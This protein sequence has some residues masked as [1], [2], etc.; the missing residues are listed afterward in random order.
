MKKLKANI[1]KALL[2]A[3]KTYEFYMIVTDDFTVN[4]VVAPEEETEYRL[5]RQLTQTLRYWVMSRKKMLD[6]LKEITRHATRELEAIN[7]NYPTNSLYLSD[8]DFKR[9]KQECMALEDEVRVL[10]FVLQ[11]KNIN[12]VFQKLSVLLKTENEFQEVG[13]CVG[14]WIKQHWSV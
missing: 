6:E 2:E 1:D 14:Q 7:D 10:N 11:Y 5:A 9:Y 4:G 13:V 3:D 8:N 12:D